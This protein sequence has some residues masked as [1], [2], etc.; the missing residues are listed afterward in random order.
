MAFSAVVVSPLYEELI[1]AIRHIT[2]K[3]GDFRLVMLATAGAY[4]PEEWNLI[5][6]APW[7]DEMSLRTALGKMLSSLQSSLSEWAFQKVQRVTILKTIEPLVRE[8][9]AEVPVPL[10]T[11]YRVQFLALSRFG[12][13]D[14]V[15]LLA[16]PPSG[17]PIPAE[18]RSTV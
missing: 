1:K 11:A 10:G 12:I 3:Y 17:S 6:S 15:V 8:I 4:G 13:D 9:T 14:A 16:A 18:V 5:L 7:L 2:S